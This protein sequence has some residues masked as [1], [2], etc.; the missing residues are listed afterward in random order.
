M[1]IELM[2]ER[3]LLSQREEADFSFGDEDED[4]EDEEV[5]EEDDVEDDDDTEIDEEAASYVDSSVA[6]D[7]GEAP[8]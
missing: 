2:R 8:M 5:E 6:D 1:T 3:E 4:D 7:D